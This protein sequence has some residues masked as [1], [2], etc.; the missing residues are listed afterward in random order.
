MVCCSDLNDPVVFGFTL[1]NDDGASIE[2]KYD[3]CIQETGN[4]GSRVV[5]NSEVSGGAPLAD[6]ANRVH[7]ESIN[8]PASE[9]DYEIVIVVT[10]L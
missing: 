10:V 2:Y 9:G 6:G 5:L 8:A 3:V 1:Q 4:P 7:S